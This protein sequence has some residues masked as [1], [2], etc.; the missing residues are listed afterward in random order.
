MVEVN[1]SL[2]SR[3]CC[4]MIEG[5]YLL[6]LALW[7]LCCAVMCFVCL[8]SDI[9]AWITTPLLCISSAVVTLLLIRAS[10]RGDKSAKISSKSKLNYYICRR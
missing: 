4:F 9:P 10:V 8:S 3:V 6:Y 2:D 5:I 7:I 1:K